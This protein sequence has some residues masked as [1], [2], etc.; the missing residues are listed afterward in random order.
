[1]KRLYQIGLL[2]LTG[3]SAQAQTYTINGTL[4]YE[5]SP[6]GIKEYAKRIGA[7][8]TLPDVKTVNEHGMDQGPLCSGECTH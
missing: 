5:S 1:M 3:L 7:L 6:R 2:I 8:A 4:T